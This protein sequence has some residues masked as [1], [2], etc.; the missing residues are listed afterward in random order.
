[1]DELFASLAKDFADE[2]LPLAQQVCALVL[3]IEQVLHSG[4]DARELVR[5]V[6]GRLH[7]IKGNSAMMGIAAI[8]SLA[9]ALEDVCGAV[10]EDG[11]AHQRRD[12][13]QLVEGGDL[14]V[15]LIAAAGEGRVDAARA[16]AFVQRL[17]DIRAGSTTDEIDASVAAPAAGEPT[18]ARTSNV[19]VEDARGSA[20]IGDRD[21]DEL[22]ELAGEAMVRQNELARVHARLA[23][24]QF[25]AGDVALMEQA[26][27][28]LGRTTREMR[29]KLL[30]VRL[31]PIATLFGRF[32][33]YVR[34]LALER[35]QAIELA[36]EGG[37][38]A[39]DR[40]IIGRL[41]EPLVHVVRNAVA[42]GVESP[43]ARIAAGKPATARVLLRAALREGRVLISVADDGRGLDLDA[44]AAKAQADGH[45]TTGLSRQDLQRLIFQAGFSTAKSVSDLA[46]RGVGLDVVAGVV[47]SL[48]GTIDVRSTP[49]QGTMFV[50][51][52]PVTV[53]LQKALVFGVDSETFA[54][55]AGFVLDT[56]ES[57]E[58]DLQEINRVLLVSWR[59]DFVRAIDAGRLLGCSGL[60][61]A[62]ARPY[63]IILHAGNKRGV[64]LVD[65]LSGVQEIVVKPLDEAL[66]GCRLISGA[67]V[68]AQGRVVPILDCLEV[69]RRTARAVLPE[70]PA[71]P[72]SEESFHVF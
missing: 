25:E 35:G 37:E 9:H 64:L 69:V 56:M 31:A 17:S 43:A 62:W 24:G 42:H 41:F 47:Q 11:G 50:L 44:I 58:K 48:G 67:T 49:G 21:V 53:S 55:P 16:D 28:D 32:R 23:R 10:L 71:T 12:V 46:G 6:R 27:A 8:A 22:L 59:G 66:S 68:L 52:L 65:W 7:T 15:A 39:V 33:R 18:V 26:L 13:E 3:E 19:E 40:A 45:D 29:H 20:R 36:I 4:G 14:V 38:T 57:R 72:R 63:A 70:R 60:A 30:V 5:G 54:V 34:D 61:Q 1:V 2:T 51:D